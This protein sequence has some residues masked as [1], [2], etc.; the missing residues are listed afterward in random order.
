MGGASY[1][2]RAIR[3]PIRRSAAE[4]L[5]S[6]TTVVGI[7]L[8]RPIAR[9]ARWAIRRSAAISI[10]RCAAVDAC[11]SGR[12]TI[13]GQLAL[14]R[15]HRRVVTA[16]I[17]AAAKGARTIRRCVGRSIPAAAGSQTL[18]VHR[19]H[20]NVR[21]RRC[22]R[23]T[24]HDRAIH[25]GRGRR[26]H[27]SPRIRCSRETGFGRRKRSAVGHSRSLQRSRSDVRGPAIDRLAIHER[28]ARGRS[29]RARFMCVPV[30]EIVV[31]KVIQCIYVRNPRIRDIYVAEIIPARVI[32]GTERFA[33]AQ[34]EPA[35]SA[36]PAATKTET[37][38]KP[39]SA[40][41]KTDEGRSI[42]WPRVNGTGA[43]APTAT[44]KRPASVVIRREAPGR[45]VHPGPAPWANPVPIAIAIRRPADCYRAGIPNRPV[46][47]FFS[48]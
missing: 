45:I 16:S 13:V 29:D 31:I 38:P 6:T 26:G 20:G 48:P 15:R 9:S 35:D 17:V 14:A 43:P 24:R 4:P 11:V 25:H 1:L 47:G 42:E 19:P 46:V 32:P 2:V 21:S 22:R 28:V 37:N 7:S 3:R 41:K 36:A 39:K 18:R 44:Y 40:T 23:R 33:P 30:V 12:R 8:S 5:G 27:A 34:R 10:D